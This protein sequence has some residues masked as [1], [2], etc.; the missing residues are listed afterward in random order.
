MVIDGNP[1]VTHGTFGVPTLVALAWNDS[2]LGS[3][4]EAGF[5]CLTLVGRNMMAFTI[6]TVELAVTMC[7]DPWAGYHAHNPDSQI[8]HTRNNDSLDRYD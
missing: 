6:G 2:V 5:H 3:A 8:G 1:F 4:H 7:N